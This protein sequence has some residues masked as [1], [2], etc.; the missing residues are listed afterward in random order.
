VIPYFRIGLGFAE[1]DQ[2]LGSSREAN[3]RPT[4]SLTS[5]RP[6]AE[7]AVRWGAGL[8]D[9][10]R[11]DVEVRFRLLNPRSVDDQT[12]RYDL[13]DV[14]QDN[15]AAL[16]DDARVEDTDGINR[17][18]ATVVDAP[19]QTSLS[20]RLA[21]LGFDRMSRVIHTG[22]AR[23]WLYYLFT[24][25]PVM[26]IVVLVVDRVWAR[27]TGG[28]QHETS[29]IV[30]GVSLCVLVNYIFMRSDERV[31]DA[32]VVGPILGVWA[33]GRVSGWLAV[34]R[35]Q[36][37]RPVHLSTTVGLWAGTAVVAITTLLS[38]ADISRFGPGW[39][40]VWAGGPTGAFRH[41]VDVVR[42]LKQRPQLDVWRPND[43]A[44]KEATRYVRDCTGRSDRLLVT[45]FA[46]EV[47]FYAE[48][49][50]AAGQAFFYPGFFTTD[51]D[52]R[53]ALSRL[54]AEPVPVALM[55]AG[56]GGRFFATEYP[57][58]ADY[59]ERE[60][61]VAGKFAT[62]S[63]AGFDVLVSRHARATGTHPASGLPCFR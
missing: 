41:G 18:L 57:L 36:M 51:R 42:T 49:L 31:S 29:L 6:S 4:F 55:L 59:L 34:Y 46:P 26:V 48:R 12:F 54:A 11:A 23:F 1:G 9:S 40:A 35:P 8:S 27:G 53:R 5:D 14:S 39:E 3:S 17:G 15:I 43:P 52:Q 25:M 28:S 20:Q 62:Q 60:F 32:S 33:I 47:Y 30:A 22:N 21:V 63:A 13:A 38:A 24:L 56:D 44:L 16:I 37:S 61:R 7:V 58:L 50:F 2:A 45:W 10:V 19:W